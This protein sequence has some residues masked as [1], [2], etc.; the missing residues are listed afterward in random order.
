MCLTNTINEKNMHPHRTRTRVLGLF[1]GRP[2]KSRTSSFKIHFCKLY[3]GYTILGYTKPLYKIY[4][5]MMDKDQ[6]KNK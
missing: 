4:Q 3:Q 6:K 2:T 1:Y 5:H